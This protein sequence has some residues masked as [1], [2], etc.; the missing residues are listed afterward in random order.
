MPAPPCEKQGGATGTPKKTKPEVYSREPGHPCHPPVPSALVPNPEGPARNSHQVTLFSWNIGGKPIDD[1]LKAIDHSLPSRSVRSSIISFQELPRVSPGWQTTRQAGDR[2]LVQYRDDDLQWRGNG[3]LFNPEV[4]TCLRRKANPIGVWVRLKHKETGSELWVSSARLSTGVTDDVTA[5]EMQTFLKLRPAVPAQSVLLADFNTKLSWSGG[6]GKVGQLRSTCGRTDNVLSEVE[7]HG[8]QFCAPKPEQWETPTSRPR[9]AGAK[10]RQIDGMAVRSLPKSDISIDEKSYMEIGGDHDRIRA[11]VGVAE[12][13][14]KGRAQ[15]PTRPRIVTRDPGTHHHF[16]QAV[17]EELA[18]THTRPKPGQRYRDPDSVKALYKQAKREGTEVSWKRAHRAR[19]EARDLWHTEKVARAGQGSWKDFKDLKPDQGPMWAVHLSEES[20]GAGKDPLIWTV[21]HFKA[22]FAAP[23]GEPPQPE[24]DRECKPSRPFSLDEL[25]AAIGKGKKGK[26][27]GLDLTSYELLSRI[28]ENH[29]S[30]SSLLRWMESIR[31]GAP[32]PQQW[33]QTVITLLPKVPNPSSPSDLRPI[34]LGSTVGK[35]FGQML[36]A[37]TR[38]ALQPSGPEQCA[39][40][41]R[42]TADYIYSAVR[43]F[44]LETEWRW[45]LH[46]MKLDISKAFDSLSRSRAL[47]YLRNALPSHMS[48]EYECWKKL[49]A[50]GTAIVR[51]P[52]GEDQVLQTRGIRQGA[53][54]SP[55]LFAVAMECALHEAQTHAKWPSEIRAA[56][57]LQVQ[58]L[59]FMDDSLIWGGSRT[60]L[61]MKCAIFKDAL[62]GWGLKVNPK[63]TAYY[64]SPYVTEKGP[65]I[66]DNVPVEPSSSLEIMGIA[67]QVPLKPSSLLDS[68]LAKARRKYFACRQVLECRGPLKERLKTFRAAVGGAALWYSAAVPPSPQALG[69]V[70]TLQQELVARMAGFRRKSTESWLDYRQRS[71]RAARQIISNCGQERWSTSWL[72][73]YWGYKGHVARSASRDSPPASAYMDRYRTYQWWVEQQR[74]ADGIKHPRSH[75]PYLSNDELRLNR[76]A[77]GKEWREVACDPAAWKGLEREWLKREDVRWS[78]GRQ[79]SITFCSTNTP[80]N[81]CSLAVE[82]ASETI[83][84]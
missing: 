49:L 40:A 41:G 48:N 81:P 12:H 28:L 75:Y 45:G 82:G 21:D 4:Y 19:R 39:H 25:E 23:P 53:V 8:F 84:G 3:V 24:W 83:P 66:V 78:S 54:E 42:Q 6:A 80:T 9:R 77:G 13:L 55:F 34:S 37:R 59:L 68:G 57:D 47:E 11:T 20:Y 63:K 31:L 26:A 17:M 62:R 76:A 67:L 38:A 1:A 35:V 79:V 74:R 65:L 36:L 72:R 10:G 44:Q 51:T 64:A 58:E 30:E 56:P 14:S 60:E 73:R 46:W 29:V 2:L 69:A 7:T 5:D 22:I 61:A 18:L 43:S 16:D 33:L 70:N 50:T 15:Q 52:W 27:V 71:L 32:I